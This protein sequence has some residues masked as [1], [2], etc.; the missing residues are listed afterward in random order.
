MLQAWKTIIT[1]HLSLSLSLSLSP[2]LSDVD[3]DS[4]QVD[5][6]ADCWM[7]QDERG[8]TDKKRPA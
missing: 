4:V 5:G 8:L 3:V 6:S 2:P 1:P 7:L